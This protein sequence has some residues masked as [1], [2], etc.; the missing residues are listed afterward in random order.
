MHV[1]HVLP[2]TIWFN[3]NRCMAF[4]MALDQGTT[5]S[6]TILFDEGG[7]VVSMAQ[8]E[9]TQHFPQPGYVE[10]DAE[11]IWRSQLQT[12][13]DAIRQ[14]E[15][16]VSEITTI[17]ITNQ[18]ETV[19]LW[20]RKSGR[21]VTRAIVWQDRRTTD[22]CRRLR[23]EGL[24]RHVHEITGLIIDPY[25]SA[26]KIAWLLNRDPVLHD[27]AVRGEIAFGTVDSWLLFKLTGDRA[28]LT[29][30]TNASR[31]MLYDIRKGRWDPELLE[32]LD[33]PAGLMPEV[34]ESSGDFGYTDSS[35]VGARIPI[36]GVAGDQQ[37]ALFGQVCHEAGMAKN[38]YGTGCFMLMHTG[39]TPI[40]NE[41]GLLTT[42]AWGLEG[43]REY[44][45]EGSVFAAGASIQWLR[46]SL[47][48]I[49]SAGETEQL[50]SSLGDNAHVYFVPA[51]AG[52]GTPHWDPTARGAIVGLTRGTGKA[53]I[54]R[55]ALESIAYQSC[56]V[57][58]A[59]Q[60][61]SGIDLLE[62]RVDGGAVAN[63]FLMQFQ[64]DML[65]VPVI[66]PEVTESTARGAAFLAGIAV[67]IWRFE[68]LS[69]LWVADRTF[70]PQMQGDDR[71]G[72]LA[73][74]SR[75][76]ERAKGW[77]E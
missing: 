43:R 69:S 6:R 13:R 73:E 60:K 7:R 77:V 35:V 33:I 37:A 3:R 56:E 14:A 22:L 58:N 63:N 66:R 27:R 11:E 68:D 24:A 67:G 65:G 44:A 48:V 21:P 2:S 38:T 41:K 62:L 71:A 20:D 28:H 61:T 46:D 29:D 34:R 10:Q 42:I 12:M 50:A 52:L 74:W 18:R 70:E 31:T 32:A 39:S 54:V 57:L 76:V 15:V 47:G 75:A 5:S 4:I 26:T 30:C 16:N 9:F 72:L 45:L 51:F 25:F 40:F 59:M 64:S 36:T 8:R 49:A 19:V 17:G 1:V 23:D 55:A 53:H